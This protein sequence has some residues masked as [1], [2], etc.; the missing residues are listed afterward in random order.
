[1]VALFLH[2]HRETVLTGISERIEEKSKKKEVVSMET[3]SGQTD[4][5]ALQF[6]DGVVVHL[7]DFAR[8]DDEAH[9]V[10]RD[11]RFGDLFHNKSVKARR[12][13][14]RENVKGTTRGTDVGGDDALADALG[15]VVEDLVLFGDGEGA[16]QRQD[17]PA[18]VLKRV[19]AHR[20]GHRFDLLQTREE[21]QHV[22][23]LLLPLID[24]L[25]SVIITLHYLVF[26]WNVLFLTDQAVAR[27]NEFN[28]SSAAIIDTES[29]LRRTLL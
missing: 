4:L 28:N 24:D 7:L 3:G 13:L 29:H 27:K 9:A 18:L 2:V 14:S 26:A 15:R 12:G 16:V 20:L 5:E 25:L 22:A 10:D 11:R 23:P 21:H 17:D 1:M 19:L 6:G 8:I